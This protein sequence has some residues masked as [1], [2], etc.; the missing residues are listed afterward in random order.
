M[1]NAHNVLQSAFQTDFATAVATSTVKL[2]NVSDFKLRPEFQTRALDQ[3]RGTLAPTHQTVLDHYASSATFEVPD[4]SY[5]DLNY[6]LEALFGTDAPAG[7]GPY[8]REYAAPTT[9]AV[10]PRFMTLQYGQTGEVWQMQDASITTLTLSGKNNGGIQVGGS[11]IGGKV[12]EGALQALADRTAVTRISGCAA[13]VAIDTWAGTIGTTV[14]AASAFAWE[15]SINANREYR[16]F[17]G[18]CVPQAYND[19]KWNGQLRLSLELNT[20]TDDY[21]IA[22]LAAANTILEKQV[23]II[24]TI[25]TTT[26]LRTFKLQFTGHS[27]KAP[28]LFSDRSGV[29]TYDLVLD[30]V[31]NPTLANWLKISTTSETAVLA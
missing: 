28:E 16:S 19:Q 27:M 10:T 14:I 2:Q 25:G 9:A 8:V 7:V 21:I 20:T 24:Y 1:L 31:Y 11:L 15:A 6:W 30:G 18:G 22:M 17:L 26:T 13:S 29:T 23:E 3:L 12:I 5:E 4:E